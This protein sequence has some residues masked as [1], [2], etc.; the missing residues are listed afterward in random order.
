MSKIETSRERRALIRK[1]IEEGRKG[2]SVSALKS[3][4]VDLHVELEE[5]YVKLAKADNFRAFVN[6]ASTNY[7]MIDFNKPLC[8]KEG[9]IKQEE[10]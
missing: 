2:F 6:Q 10:K 4:I 3:E 7:S 8:F 1:A 5:L 9:W